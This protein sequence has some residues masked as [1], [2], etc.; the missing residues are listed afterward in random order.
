M[1]WSLLPK[2]LRTF[3]IYCAPPNLGIARTWICRLNF[4]QMPIFSGLR[5]FNEPEIS[6]SGSTAISP[7]RRSCTQDF[8]FLKKSFDLSRV[9]TREPWISK[10]ARNHETTETDMDTVP[11]LFDM[12]GYTRTNRYQQYIFL[13]IIYTVEGFRIKPGIFGTETSVWSSILPSS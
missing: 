10:R 7:S 6:D 2:V 13:H 1:R 5:F 11:M 4:A 12:Y 9:W 3:K 8:Y